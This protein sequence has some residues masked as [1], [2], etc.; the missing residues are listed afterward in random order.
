[1]SEKKKYILIALIILAQLG[2]I[3]LLF[4][5]VMWA[6]VC[7]SF[8]GIATVILLIAF[9]LERKKEKKE[10]IDYDDCDY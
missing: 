8:Y 2:G 10:E 9:I 4:V 3:A 1:M 5:D 7:F 6:I